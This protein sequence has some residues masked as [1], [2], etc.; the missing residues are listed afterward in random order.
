MCVGL[1]WIEADFFDISHP[2]NGMDEV[3]EVQ[4]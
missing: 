2:D 1:I 3:S 4:L